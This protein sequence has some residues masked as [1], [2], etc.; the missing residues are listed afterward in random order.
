MKVFYIAELETLGISGNLLK[1]FQSFL[2]DREQ[3]VVLN[4]QHSK[5]APALAVVP[6]KS[7]Y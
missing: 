4:G 3:R 5:W 1:F 7:Q 2:S 6:H